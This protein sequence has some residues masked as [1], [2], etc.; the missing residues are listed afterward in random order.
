MLTLSGA[1]KIVSCGGEGHFRDMRSAK[2]VVAY[3]GEQSLT[4]NSLMLSKAG[5]SNGQ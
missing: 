4:R 3:L 1:Q 5:S 2:T